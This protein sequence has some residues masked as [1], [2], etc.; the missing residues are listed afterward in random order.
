M[1][2]ELT[3]MS[4]ESQK[5]RR[6]RAEL[7]RYLKKKW[8]KN[9]VLFVWSRTVIVQKFSVLLGCLF[10]VLWLER[11]GFCR[12]FFVLHPLVFMGCQLLRFKSVICKAKRTLKEFTA[13]S[14]LGSQGP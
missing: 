1:A 3:I 9:S 5:K 11:G 8:L 7:K 12:I 10:P 6:T 14:F 2:K 13:M 4:S